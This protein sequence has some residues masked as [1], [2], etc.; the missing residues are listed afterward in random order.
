[1]HSLFRGVTI[2]KAVKR[3]SFSFNTA[4]RV[5]F[6]EC[7][8]TLSFRRCIVPAPIP[9]W[10]LSTP[11]GKMHLKPHIVLLLTVVRLV[12]MSIFVWLCSFL[13]Q[14]IFMFRDLSF[15]TCI[16]RGWRGGVL[17]ISGQGLDFYPSSEGRV[18]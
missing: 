2:I 18:S 12:L 8:N 16:I 11:P 10:G 9:S 5:V 15:F 7:R 4:K 6:I 1:M 13:P 3:G 14:G 17:L